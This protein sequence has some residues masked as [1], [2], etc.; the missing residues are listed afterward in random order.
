MHRELRDRARSHMSR[1]ASEVS[2]RAMGAPKRRTGRKL[3]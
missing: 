1:G 3:G 2:W